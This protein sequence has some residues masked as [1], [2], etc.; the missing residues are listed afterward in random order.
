MKYFIFVGALIAFGAADIS[1]K[2]NPPYQPSGW[3]PSG[4]LLPGEYGAPPAPSLVQVSQENVRFAGQVVEIPAAAEPKNA[5]LPPSSS[6]T[7][8]TAAQ[9]QFGQ[10]NAP[11][12][13]RKNSMTIDAKNGKHFQNSFSLFCSRRTMISFVY[14]MFREQ[15]RRSHSG[16]LDN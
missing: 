5:Y 12:Q 3:R 10:L 14:K 15:R 8:S 16:S 9:Q 11:A 4:P 2:N 7:S 1:L 13:V 6:Q